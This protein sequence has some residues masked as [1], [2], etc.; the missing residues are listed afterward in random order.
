MYS[1]SCIIKYLLVIVF[2]LNCFSNKKE[3]IETFENSPCLLLQIGDYS[4]TEEHFRERIKKVQSIRYNKRTE[5]FEAVRE[6][7]DISLKLGLLIAESYRLELDKD[8]LVLYHLEEEKKRIFENYLKRIPVYFIESVTDKM[9]KKAW[10]RRNRYFRFGHIVVR[11]KEDIKIVLEK[12]NSGL[13]ITDLIVDN[14][15][16]KI[17]LNERG[18]KIELNEITGGKILPILEE[19]IWKMDVGDHEIVKINSDFHILTVEGIRMRKREPL[20]LIKTNIRNNIVKAYYEYNNSEYLNIMNTNTIWIDEIKLKKLDLSKEESI[21][22]IEKSINSNIAVKLKCGNVFSAEDLKKMILNLPKEDQKF[23]QNRSTRS[24]AIKHLILEIPALKEYFNKNIKESY[25]I[26]EFIKQKVLSNIKING[27]DILSKSQEKGIDNDS[28]VQELFVEKREEILKQ[29]INQQPDNHNVYEE[30]IKLAYSMG[31]DRNTNVIQ[32]MEKLEKIKGK[33]RWTLEIAKK[34]QDEFIF[35]NNDV[36][37]QINLSLDDSEFIAIWE[38]GSLTVGEFKDVLSKYT[39]NTLKQLRESE[40]LKKIAVYSIVQDKFPLQKKESIKLNENVVQKFDPVWDSR[41]IKISDIESISDEDII[42]RYVNKV[43]KAGELKRLIKSWPEERVDQF[44]KNRFYTL[45]TYLRGMVY[46]MKAEDLK[47]DEDEIIQSSCN[48]AKE[49][50]MLERLYD[51]I[52]GHSYPILM[53]NNKLEEWLS[54]FIASKNENALLNLVD[55]VRKKSTIKVN[56]ELME[57]IGLPINSDF[58]YL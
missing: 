11:A 40:K 44:K 14:S 28:A 58:R 34:L 29:I 41:T 36:I 35:F 43:L 45:N 4:L 33:I 26:E 19:K 46:L 52:I 25:M 22:N 56:R 23:F 9:I 1:K 31:I 21:T 53:G 32:R 18:M 50:F 47:L 8:S 38:S 17:E 5:S 30:I 7:W 51:K 57:K 10:K 6:A 48:R 54:E 27:H 12:L 24:L 13:S 55:E 2:F 15:L 42:A 20:S 3:S 49:W 16:D 37:Q 39:S